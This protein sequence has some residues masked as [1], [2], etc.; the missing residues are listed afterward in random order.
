MDNKSYKI[1]LIEDN[2]QDVFLFREIIR[3]EKKILFDIHVESTL[4]GAFSALQ[5]DR[6]DII[7]TDL[8]LPDSKGLDTVIKLIEKYSHLPIIVLTDL[9]DDE[10]GV[11]CIKH[12]AQDYIVKEELETHKIAQTIRYSSNRKKIEK[13][14]SESYDRFKRIAENIQDDLTIIRNNEIVYL[15]ARMAEITG[16]SFDEMK[17]KHE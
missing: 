9:K 6:F 17:L 14:H 1:L 10:V 2:E 16:Y 3:E 7:L 8:E 5:K 4:K 11:S 13:E 12:G 15:N